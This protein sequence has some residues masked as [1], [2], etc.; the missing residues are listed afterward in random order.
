MDW[1][2]VPWDL[3]AIDPNMVLLFQ[4]T[5]KSQSSWL[6]GLRPS[7]FLLLSI[8]HQ[9]HQ[10]PYHVCT[11]IY[12]KSADISGAYLW[13][14]GPVQSPRLFLQTT[15]PFSFKAS[16]RESCIQTGANLKCE[17]NL[18][19]LM[20]MLKFKFAQLR[21]EGLPLQNKTVQSRLQ[22]RFSE[23]IA[24]FHRFLVCGWSLDQY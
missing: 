3:N 7:P 5:W 16:E 19:S 4:E 6:A 2:E 9:P 13:V 24:M 23:L 14:T 21:M 15:G 20:R 17:A 1:I 12:C 10:R 22:M 18:F 8:Y 11:W